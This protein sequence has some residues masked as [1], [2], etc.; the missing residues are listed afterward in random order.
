MYDKNRTEHGHSAFHFDPV[1]MH[2]KFFRTTEQ[3]T[4]IFK[5]IRPCAENCITVR[6]FVPESGVLSRS[7]PEEGGQLWRA[8]DRK[9]LTL[10]STKVDRLFGDTDHR[11][12]SM[13]GGKLGG[14]WKGRCSANRVD[15]RRR[16]LLSADILRR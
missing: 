2:H 7:T 12:I 11:V 6:T 4:H 16:F 9:N 1:D 14:T 15:S 13:A 10:R 8:P 3:G 5:L